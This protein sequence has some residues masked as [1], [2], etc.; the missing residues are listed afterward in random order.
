MHAVALP[1]RASP[2]VGATGASGRFV[3]AG[4][5]DRVSELAGVLVVLPGTRVVAVSLI[6]LNNDLQGENRMHTGALL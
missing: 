2:I 1:R 6:L 4:L 5:P 3:V